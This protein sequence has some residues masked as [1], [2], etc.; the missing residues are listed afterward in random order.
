MSSSFR[1]A[2]HMNDAEEIPLGIPVGTPLRGVRINC[3]AGF[4]P[5]MIA[6][7]WRA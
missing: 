1:P 2:E 5:A 6:P 3:G 4:M 7:E